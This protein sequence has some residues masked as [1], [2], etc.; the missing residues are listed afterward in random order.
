MHESENK[1]VARALTRRCSTARAQCKLH[2]ASRGRQALTLATL[3][4]GEALVRRHVREATRTA[5]LEVTR[6]VADALRYLVTV[7]KRVVLAW[8]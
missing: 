2:D 1:L 4:A 7:V 3:A 8:V 6:L 5:T